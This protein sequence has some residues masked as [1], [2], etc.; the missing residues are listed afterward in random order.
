MDVIDIINI[1][2]GVL[3]I[4]AG[5]TAHIRISRSDKT[6]ITD[7]KQSISGDGNQQAGRDVIS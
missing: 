4:L 3:G 7:Q 5:A 1:I 2:L 6:T